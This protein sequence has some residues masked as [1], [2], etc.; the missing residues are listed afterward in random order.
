MGSETPRLNYPRT[1]SPRHAEEQGH[2]ERQGLETIRSRSP[3]TLADASRPASFIDGLDVGEREE[4]AGMQRLR[5][6]VQTS[7]GN[8]RKGSNGPSAALVLK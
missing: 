6:T 7:V 8:V 5:K 3:C 4:V 2:A 1:Q